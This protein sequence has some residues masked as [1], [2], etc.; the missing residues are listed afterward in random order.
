MPGHGELDADPFDA[1]KHR[2]PRCLIVGCFYRDQRIALV[3]DGFDL[4]QQQLEPVQLPVDLISHVLRQRLSIAGSQFLKAP[5]SILV[6][7]L[8]VGH[9]L[10]E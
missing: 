5:A 9:T 10:R 8:V 3:F 1:K 6:E 4:F 2:D 7:R